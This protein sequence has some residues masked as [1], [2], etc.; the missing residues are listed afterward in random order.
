MVCMHGTLQ[1]LRMHGQAQES[2]LPGPE[3]PLHTNSTQLPG[4]SKTPL[5]SMFVPMTA[6]K[7]GESLSQHGQRHAEEV[8][9]VCV[10]RPRGSMRSQLTSALSQA[11]SCSKSASCDAACCVR[12]AAYMPS[13][14]SICEYMSS[15]SASTSDRGPCRYAGMLLHQ[16]A[17]LLPC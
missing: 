11:P 16:I 10:A 13:G 14:S 2:T 1:V 8:L 6:C 7:A 4:I 15:S 3:H 5:S 17:T 12:A 9:H